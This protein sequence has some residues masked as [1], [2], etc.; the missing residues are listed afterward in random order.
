[1]FNA[2]FPADQLSADKFEAIM[3]ALERA[4]GTSAALITQVPH[5]FYPSA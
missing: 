3:N 4:T 1:M 2:K 5:P